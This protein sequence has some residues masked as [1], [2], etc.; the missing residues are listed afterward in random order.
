[1]LSAIGRLTRAGRRLAPAV[2][3]AASLL[4]GLSCDRS[5]PGF[6]AGR[7][8]THL[9]EQVRFGPRVPGSAARDS[10]AVYITRILGAHGGDVSAQRFEFQDPYSER[11]IPLI[12]VIA[13]FYPQHRK[14]IMLAA[15]YDSRPW[16]DEERVD[17]LRSQPV[18]GA[19]DGASGVAVLLEIG[20]LLGLRDPGVGVDLV[21][22]DGE[23]Y[24]KSGDLEYYL[25]GSKHFVSTRVDYRPV[26]GVLLDM[27]A[28]NRSFIAR[29]GYSRANA[30]ELTD[31]LFARAERLGLDFFRPIDAAAIY[32]DHVPF[33]KAG[34]DVVDLFGYEYPWWHTVDDVPKNCSRERLGQVG[35]LLADFLYDFPF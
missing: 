11:T 7:A 23:D 8:W 26:C 18:P 2:F 22:F 35:V 24:G 9:V 16:A 21:F 33:L 3:L 17:S 29:E 30:P 15:H 14:R 28:G 31:E 32:D 25:L 5:H 27:V 12:N 20:R 34:I 10:V 1:L 13:N 6:D 19:H 4:P